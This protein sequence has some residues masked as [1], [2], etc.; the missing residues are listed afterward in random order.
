MLKYSIQFL[1]L[2]L[3]VASCN[4]IETGDS[5]SRKDFQRFRELHLIENGERLYKFYSE[6]KKS[7]AGNFYTDRRMASYWIDERDS[8]KNS[9]EF[10]FYEDIIRI[11]TCY[12]AGFTFAPFMLVTRKDSTQFKVCVEGSKQEIAEFFNGAIS[13]WKS[14]KNMHE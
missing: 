12:N 7:V 13:K 10:A 2:F 8:T 3:F 1:I 4:R 11:D 6:F 5:L 14:R 9:T